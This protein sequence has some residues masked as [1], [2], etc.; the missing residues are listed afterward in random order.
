MARGRKDDFFLFFRIKLVV[1]AG[2]RSATGK[3]SQ[4]STPAPECCRGRRVRDRPREKPANYLHPPQSAV[5]CV[6]SDQPLGKRKTC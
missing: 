1:G 6:T 5:G 2:A 4:L 3:T